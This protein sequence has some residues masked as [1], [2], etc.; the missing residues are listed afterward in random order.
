MLKQKH[1]RLFLLA[2]LAVL[3][4]PRLCLGQGV[5]TTVAGD[6]TLGFSGD[7]GPATSARI[8]GRCGALGVAADDAGNF[9]IADV[10]N[11]RVRKVNPAGI[12]TTVA[13]GGTAVGPNPGD[14]GPATSAQVFLPWTALET[15]ILQAPPSAR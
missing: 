2:T 6:G 7:G 13:G 9:Y 3:T 10:C 5:I 4:A 14:G 15:S 8:G 11:N 12:I 1:C